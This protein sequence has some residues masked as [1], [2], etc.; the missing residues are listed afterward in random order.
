MKSSYEINM[1]NYNEFEHLLTMAL[2]AFAWLRNFWLDSDYPT[3]H[4]TS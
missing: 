3:N 1:K 2:E 4:H